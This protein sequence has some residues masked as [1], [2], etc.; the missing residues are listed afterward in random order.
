MAAVN[1]IFMCALSWTFVGFFY[2]NNENSLMVIY[3][4]TNTMDICTGS[5]KYSVTLY[6]VKGTQHAA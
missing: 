1:I 2:E 3:W 4:G 6:S 5:Q